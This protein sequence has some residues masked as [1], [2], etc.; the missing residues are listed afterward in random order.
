MHQLDT[1]YVKLCKIKITLKMKVD[2]LVHCAPWS[3][4]RA[5]ATIKIK[6]IYINDMPSAAEESCFDHWF[7]EH[8]G[9]SCHSCQPKHSGFAPIC[10]GL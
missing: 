2:A 5:N 10:A 6:V 4:N 3:L 9:C 8:L 1:N 7:E